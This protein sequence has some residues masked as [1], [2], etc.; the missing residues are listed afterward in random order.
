MTI[1]VVRPNHPEDPFRYLVHSASHRAPT[2]G[3]SGI[4]PSV[5]LKMALLAQFGTMPFL[6]HRPKGAGF[7]EVAA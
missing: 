5:N 3:R 2:G 7:K 4:L 6:G 1:P